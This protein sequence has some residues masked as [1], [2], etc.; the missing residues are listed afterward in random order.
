MAGKTQDCSRFVIGQEK[1][2]IGFYNNFD[3]LTAVY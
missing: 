3:M 1:P 2:A